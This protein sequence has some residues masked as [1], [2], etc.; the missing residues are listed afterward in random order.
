MT[1]KELQMAVHECAVEHG[2]WEE[3]RSVPECLA[4]IHSEISEALEDYRNGAMDV[5]YEG[6]K[7]VGFPVE[8]ADSVIRI[9]DLAERMN[10]DLEWWIAAKHSYNRTRPFRH[11]NKRA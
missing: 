4:L 9:T 11:G 8:L 7:P 6:E 2:W 3:D 1:I 5:T 10:I